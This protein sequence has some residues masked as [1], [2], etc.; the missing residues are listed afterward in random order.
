[1]VSPMPIPE[2]VQGAPQV[3]TNKK[4]PLTILEKPDIKF[5]QNIG[6]YV[7]VDPWFYA[8]LLEAYRRSHGITSS[9]D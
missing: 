4:I 3:L 5:E 6:G 2:A 1:M 9:D 8:R 7:V